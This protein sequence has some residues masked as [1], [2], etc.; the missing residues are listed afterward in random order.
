MGFKH[1]FHVHFISPQPFVRFSLNITQRVVVAELMAQ[2][3]RDSRSRSQFKVMALT[4]EF[5]VH[6][7][8]PKPFDFH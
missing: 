8:S 2:L 1:E 4:L 6:T 5:G 7:V 3:S